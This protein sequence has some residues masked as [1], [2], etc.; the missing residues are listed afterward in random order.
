MSEEICESVTWRSSTILVQIL[1][2]LPGALHTWAYGIN[3]LG[4]I[5]GTTLIAMGI[6]VFYTRRVS[7]LLLL[8]RSPLSRVWLP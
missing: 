6:M 4:Q 8:L 3:N 1:S 5:I 2:D 7:S